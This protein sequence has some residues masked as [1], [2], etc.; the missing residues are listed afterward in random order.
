MGIL[1]ILFFSSLMTIVRILR[2][3]KETPQMT[4]VCILHIQKN[5]LFRQDTYLRNKKHMLTCQG[6]TGCYRAVNHQDG[7]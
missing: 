1:R 5:N 7:S 6:G 3:Q 2:L 4:F